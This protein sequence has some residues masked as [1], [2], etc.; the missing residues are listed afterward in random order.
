MRLKRRMSVS[1][2]EYQANRVRITCL[3]FKKNYLDNIVKFCDFCLE[4]CCC[5]KCQ[6]K[7]VRDM[8]KNY[9]VSKLNKGCCGL[10]DLYHNNAV[11]DKKI[12][13]MKELQHCAGT[14]IQHICDQKTPNKQ[15]LTVSE[16]LGQNIRM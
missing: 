15:V 12:Q 6:N 3:S 8:A 5:F 10:Y 7:A 1:S 4:S 9:C 13:I 14:Q 2:K 11:M 16:M